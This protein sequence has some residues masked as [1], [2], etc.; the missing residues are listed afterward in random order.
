M[1]TIEDNFVT[2]E[3]AL[4]IKELGFNE[5][6]MKEFHFQELLNNSTGEELRNSE[7]TELYGEQDI[8]SAPLWQQVF[9]WF[10]EEYEM[11]YTIE[12]SKKYG[13]AFCIYSENEDI[14]EE[15]SLAYQSYQEAQLACLDKLI[16]IVEQ[17]KK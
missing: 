13:F 2:Y 12:G 8:I 9:A 11:Y 10:R 4:K 7:L 17:G 15:V 1:K 3:Q 6:C 14:E 5:P 16:K